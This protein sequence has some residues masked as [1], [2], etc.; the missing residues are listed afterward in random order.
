[1]A[2]GIQLSDFTVAE[3]PRA[4]EHVRAGARS[5]ADDAPPL[6]IG[7]FWAWHIKED[8]EVSLREARRELIWRRSLAA[9]YADDL[10]AFCHDEAEVGLVLA[11]YMNFL[12][13]FWSGSGH[14]DGVPDDLVERLVHGMSSAGDLGDLDRELDRVLAFRDAGITELALRLGDDPMEALGIIGRHVLPALR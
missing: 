9:Q 6:R 3:V 13:A 14:I 10:R 12:A 7:N 2:D 11:N 1:M 4:I 5:R 8:R